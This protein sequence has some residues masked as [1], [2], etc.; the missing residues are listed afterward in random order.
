MVVSEVPAGAG[1]TVVKVSVGKEIGKR[2][3]DMGF[4]EGAR[5]EVIRTGLFKDPLEVRIL[6]YK[7][8]IRRSEAAKIEIKLE[9]HGVN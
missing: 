5:G 7:I 2:L 8:L 3:A 9:G 4:T 6:G 1:F